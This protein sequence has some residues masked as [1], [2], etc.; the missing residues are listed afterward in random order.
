MIQQGS[1]QALLLLDEL[2]EAFPTR[3]VGGVGCQGAI[4]KEDGLSNLSGVILSVQLPS[5]TG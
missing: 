1:Q 4:A 5:K 3:T 2:E